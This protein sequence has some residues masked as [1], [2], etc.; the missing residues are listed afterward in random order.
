MSKTPRSM[1]QSGGIGTPHLSERTGGGH[2]GA[3]LPHAGSAYLAY[4]KERSASSVI[5]GGYT[6]TATRAAA[7][8]PIAA[9]SR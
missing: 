4:K 1:A 7:A 5:K 3:G 9:R 2:G 8:R 6:N